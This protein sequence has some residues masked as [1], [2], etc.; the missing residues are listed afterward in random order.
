MA[1]VREHLERLRRADVDLRL[2]PD[3]EGVH[4]MRVESRRL[5]TALSVYRTLFDE[6]MARHLERELKFLGRVLSQVRDRQVASGLLAER[7]RGS[8]HAE[9]VIELYDRELSVDQDRILAG[10]RSALSSERYTAL[11]TG[12]DALA[13]VDGLAP[14]AGEPARTVLTDN[15][16]SA[17]RRLEDD[18]RAARKKS[19]VER[20]EALHDLR[21][22][23]KRLRY[24]CEV[25]APVAGKAALRMVQRNKELQEVLGS[26]LDR[27]ALAER[28]EP[29]TR[30]DGATA[31]DGFLLGRLHER[32]EVEI[33]AAA[34]EHDRAVRRVSDGKATRWL[35]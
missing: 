9:A 32:L 16:R 11:L 10:M 29:L 20:I 3:G 14:V 33:G 30:L 21:K 12:L 19:G 4:D 23:A 17:L 8:D 35:R 1:Y 31:A 5:R 34:R 15:V 6:A 7:L 24:A 2:D 25:V 26:H 22:S 27:V 13:E 18:A 28:L